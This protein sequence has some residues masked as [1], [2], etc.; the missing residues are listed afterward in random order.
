MCWNYKWG[1]L[2]VYTKWG[3]THKLYIQSAAPPPRNKQGH[4]HSNLPYYIF[5]Y[6]VNYTSLKLRTSKHILIDTHITVVASV[7]PNLW[8]TQFSGVAWHGGAMDWIARGPRFESW[9]NQ[10]FFHIHFEWWV[11]QS[12]EAGLGLIYWMVWVWYKNTSHENAEWVH[13]TSSDLMQVRSYFW[14]QHFNLLCTKVF[15]IIE[16]FWALSV[17][18]FECM[19]CYMNMSYTCIPA[20]NLTYNICRM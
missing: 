16:S 9:V 10:F 8:A 4:C 18:T 11:W 13:R 6:T 17:I 15:F 2:S 7:T 14:R 3:H 19:L 1:Q 12:N 5:T 20:Y